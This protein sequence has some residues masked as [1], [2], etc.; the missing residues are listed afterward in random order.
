MAK[1]KVY[2]DGLTDDQSQQ[3]IR[4]EAESI[5]A[6]LSNVSEGKIAWIVSPVLV[7]EIQRSPQIERRRENGALL[8]L[9]TH[10]IEVSNLVLIRARQL[11]AAGYG[12]FDA[13]HLACAEAGRVDVLLTTD[14]KF[15]KR[16]SR[17]ES[18]WYPCG[19]RYHGWRRRPCDRD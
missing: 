7:E 2:L 18:P 5:E 12:G 19:T 17:K 4:A 15:V 14:D 1:M 16:A 3:R 6:I 9:A 8:A 13:L 11:E 10:T